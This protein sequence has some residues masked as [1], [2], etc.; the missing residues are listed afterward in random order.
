MLVLYHDIPPGFEEINTVFAEADTDDLIWTGCHPEIYDR[1]RNPA[2]WYSSCIRT[3]T[4]R[5]VKQIR[6]NENTI[7]FTHA[8]EIKSGQAFNE[9][10]LNNLRSWNNISKTKG[11]VVLY[12]GNIFFRRSDG[13]SLLNWKDKSA[14][15]QVW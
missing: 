6:N 5:D 12:D 9:D 10:F 3:Y 7:R 11:G 4:E 8:Y 1:K 2:V 15:R 14:F 13:I